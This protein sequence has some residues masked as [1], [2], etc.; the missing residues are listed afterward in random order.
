M[1]NKRSIVSLFLAFAIVFMSV[2]PVYAYDGVATLATWDLVDSGKH[3][4]WDGE[5]NYMNYFRTAVNT[6]NAY[7]PGVIRADSWTVIEDVKI[8]DYSGDDSIT[9]K[10]SSNGTIKFNQEVMDTLSSNN[11]TKACLFALGTALGLGKTDNSKDVM[12][13]YNTSITTL[14]DNDKVSYDEAYKKY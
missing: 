8:S 2:L 11:K 6:W 10:I 12:Y 4:D 9:V 5:T 3:L 13:K 1:K 14:S 7:K